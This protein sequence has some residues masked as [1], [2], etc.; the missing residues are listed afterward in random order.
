MI[1]STLNLPEPP[2]LAK[3]TAWSL[4]NLTQIAN[5]RQCDLINR[6]ALC[7]VYVRNP[8]AFGPVTAAWDC[9]ATKVRRELLYSLLP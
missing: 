9:I 3:E 1:P 7:V 2:S 6:T 8:E 4:R 5:N